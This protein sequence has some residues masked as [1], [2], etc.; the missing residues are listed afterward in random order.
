M[1]KSNQTEKHAETPHPRTLWAW[2]YLREMAHIWGIHRGMIEKR[3][4]GRGKD[5]NKYKT[6]THTLTWRL[7]SFPTT[8]SSKQ[9][10]ATEDRTG[11]HATA[12]PSTP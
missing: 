10:M 11:N 1:K 4:W 3:G 2:H 7:G 8:S 9:E 6:E 5:E 12:T